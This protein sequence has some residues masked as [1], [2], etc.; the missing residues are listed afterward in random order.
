MSTFQGGFAVGPCTG[1]SNNQTV[2]VSW[3]GI[4][5]LGGGTICEMPSVASGL[6]RV[7]INT[8]IPFDVFVTGSASAANC[9]GSVSFAASDSIPV[10]GGAPIPCGSGGCDVAL[11]WNG[12]IAMSR[13]LAF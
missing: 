12:Q 6:P 13:P 8:P 11:L 7:C 5:C 1:L 9:A 4:E 2:T 3:F 10:P